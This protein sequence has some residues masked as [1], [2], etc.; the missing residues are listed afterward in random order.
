MGIARFHANA[1]SLRILVACFF[2]G[3]VTAILVAFVI[4]YAWPADRYPKFRGWGAGAVGAPGLGAPVDWQVWHHRAPG[5]QRN[6]YFVRANLPEA[7]ELRAFPRITAGA[8]NG[9]A[10]R[11]HAPVAAGPSGSPCR[12]VVWTFGWPLPCVSYE[13]ACDSLDVSGFPPGA[14][15]QW[16]NLGPPPAGAATGLQPYYWSVPIGK[17]RLPLLPALP[18]LACNAVV[19]T[20]P[21]L[22]V[23]MLLS[24]VRR[25]FRSRRGLCPSCRYKLAGLPPGSACPE[26][27]ESGVRGPA[28]AS[29]SPE[30]K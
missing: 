13:D 17:Q 11:R 21:W 22:V 26:C 16:G 27:G 6:E 24:P 14:W 28:V 10:M 20:V 18:A 30:P 5:I 2:L 29:A 7:A 3:A 8:A 23:V 12:F 1:L 4:A 15:Q 19:Y 25:H 9:V